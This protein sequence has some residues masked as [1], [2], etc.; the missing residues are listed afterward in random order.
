V[1]IDFAETGGKIEY[2]GGW[3]GVIEKDTSKNLK[4]IYT[5]S[6]ENNCWGDQRV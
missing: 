2:G 3:Y 5:P 1:A 4:L 6:G